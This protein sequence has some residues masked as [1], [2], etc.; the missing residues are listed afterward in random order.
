MTS[1]PASG[2]CVRTT[3]QPASDST[4]T[5]SPATCAERQRLAMGGGRP[6][7]APWQGR[8][9]DMPSGTPARSIHASRPASST[10]PGA[11]APLWRP[12][13]PC[14]G[15]APARPAPGC[16]RRAGPRG[17]LET[18]PMRVWWDARRPARRGQSNR[19][20]MV[21]RVTR[22]SS[23]CRRSYRK[24]RRLLRQRPA[25][26][27]DISAP[28]SCEAAATQARPPCPLNHRRWRRRRRRA[29]H[30]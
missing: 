20:R 13:W 24:Q 3:L 1:R 2:S 14:S 4:T 12:R 11:P 19:R 16:R 21:D 27:G 17:R 5:V 15:A 7:L 26:Q 18:R 28:G 10:R 6:K 30:T 22:G 29:A 25:E 8:R 23:G 9:G